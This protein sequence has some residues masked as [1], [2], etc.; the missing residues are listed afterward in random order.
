LF[1]ILGDISIIVLSVFF[2]FLVRFEGYIPSRYYPNILGIV[3]LSFIFLIPIFYFYRLYH[4]NWNYVSID[5]LIRIVKAVLLG[6][7]LTTGFFFVFREINIFSGFPRS[8]LFITYFFI[9]IFVGSLRFAK[10]V[11]LNLFTRDTEKKERTLIVGAGDAGELILRNILNF[12]ISPFQV[13]GFVDDADSRQ[14]ILIHGIP[15]LGRIKDIPIIARNYNIQSLIIAMP[16]VD[17][18]IIKF[19]VEK[20]REAGIK[21]I[22]IIPPIEEVFSGKVNIFQLRDIRPE[23]LLSRDVVLIDKKF[24]ENFMRGKRVLVTGAA[25]SIGSELCRQLISFLPSQI[26]LLDQ[27]ETGIF[28]IE[29]EMNERFNEIKNILK[30]RDNFSISIVPV[31]ADIR[32]EKKINSIFKKYK[33]EIVFHAAAYKHVPLMEKNPDEAVKNNVFGTKILAEASLENRVE[34]FIFISTD[35]AVNPS[36]VMGAT[37]RIGEM[38]CQAL[39]QKKKTK[40]ISVRFGN[41]LN[42]R[43]NVISIFREKIKKREPIE[44]TH[45]DM[46]RYFMITSEACQLVLEAATMGK[47]GEVF[48]LEMGNPVKIVELAKSIIELFGLEPDKDIP[49]VFTNPRPGEKIFEEILVKEEESLPTTNDKIFIAKLAE[50]DSKELEKGLK[51]LIKVVEMNDYEGIINILKKIVPNFNQ[52][53]FS[54]A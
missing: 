47:G 11:Y 13:L 14:G 33:P 27:E 7:L 15:V 26:V 18:E 51:E 10:R 50:V 48:V 46:K 23:E 3:I 8:T 9:F 17:A 54:K 19:S 22:K 35:K 5:E 34:K 6:F 45:P 4:F 36:S 24:I 41:V 21:K 20:S 32:D 25:G 37:K 28:N 30:K 43:G 52:T 31:I 40:F 2:A 53:N 16:S 49:I 42:S 38:I 39:N 29:R 1:F 12:R 44:V